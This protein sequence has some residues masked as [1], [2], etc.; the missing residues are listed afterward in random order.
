MALD[1][2]NF[3]FYKLVW[4]FFSLF[5]GIYWKIS[6]V[7][8]RIDRINAGEL[9]EKSAQVGKILWRGKFGE[10]YFTQET[11]FLYTHE[12]FDDPRCV[13][14]DDVTLYCIAENGDAVFVQTPSNVNIYSSDINPFFYIAQFNK[15]VKVIKIPA[16]SFH[17]LAS[18]IGD[19]QMEV[20]LISSTGRCGSTALTQMFEAVPGL[21]TISEPDALTNLT[22][23]RSS[24]DYETW[25]KIYKSA[26][27]LQCKP[28]PSCY[29]I[30]TRSSSTRDVDTVAELFPNMRQL[31]LYRNGLKT[32]QS[33]MK[34]FEDL[35][36]FRFLYAC[37]TNIL[38][39]NIM[40]ERLSRFL[41]KNLV[42]DRKEH[43][44]AKE[45]SF[46]KNVSVFGMMTLHWAAMIHE[47]RKLYNDGI[48]IRAIRFED[49][50][51]NPAKA[52]EAI[53]KY[54]ELSTSYVAE[55]VKSLEKD[56][57][58]G[59]LIGKKISER[60]KWS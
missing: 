50:V 43:S 18:E 2:V 27:R 40:P 36:F 21:V 60:G 11:D 33:I 49:I 35:L 8:R 47:Y 9:Y 3:L 38:L 4:A 30:K 57:Q 5:Q 19:P 15:A 46:L 51:S 56:S 48:K 6:G 13:L 34:T 16:K 12:R 28:G 20:V 53:F 45:D 10:N 39:R 41:G 25:K 22:T 1:L 7:Q 23:Y 37:Q 52:C 26:I 29:C 44:W 17:K 54:C 14:T 42:P 59:T 31:F 32:I 55:A 58:R 24:M